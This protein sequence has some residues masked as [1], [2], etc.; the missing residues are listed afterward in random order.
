MRRGYVFLLRSTSRRA[1]AVS[2]GAFRG[3]CSLYDG[4]LRER[5]AGYRHVSRTGI[6]FG[7]RSAQL[8]G[9][10]GVR[11]ATPGPLVVLH[12]GQ[13]TLRR[14]DKAFAAFFRRVKGR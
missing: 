7:D 2:P 1:Q 3:H 6:R 12:P 10:P 14:L 9:D 11:P 13:A 4:A 8:R 5:R